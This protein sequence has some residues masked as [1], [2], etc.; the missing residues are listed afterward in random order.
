[1]TWVT[2]SRHLIITVAPQVLAGNYSEEGEYEKSEEGED[3]EL[4]VENEEELEE[5]KEEESRDES[6]GKLED[7]SGSKIVEE[8][9]EEAMKVHFPS[10]YTFDQPDVVEMFR[11]LE[12]SRLRKYLGGPFIFWNTGKLGIYPFPE[13]VLFDLSIKQGDNNV[14]GSTKSSDGAFGVLVGE[15][16]QINSPRVF[17]ALTVASTLIMMK[18]NVDCASGSTSYQTGGKPSTRSKQPS[19]SVILTGA[20][21]SK[22]MNESEA[23]SSSLKSSNKKDS[24][25]VDSRLS[26]GPS[27]LATTPMSSLST[28][29]TF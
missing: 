18:N 5:E 13:P 14:C 19:A 10:V 17:T 2:S 12:Y 24:K 25:S 26:Q 29:S 23:S 20:K 21:R 8:S 7:G 6:N 27:V 9:E 15:P 28:P 16:E 11:A 3:E 22:T 1:M 4:E